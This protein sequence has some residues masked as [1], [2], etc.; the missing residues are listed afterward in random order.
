MN[1]LK[2]DEFETNLNSSLEAYS[3]RRTVADHDQEVVP[4]PD[5]MQAFLESIDT[6][7]ADPSFWSGL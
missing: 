5:G 7:F 4:I 1:R 3:I 2:H 6:C